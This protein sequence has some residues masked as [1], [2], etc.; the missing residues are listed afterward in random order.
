MEYFTADLLQFFTE[1][2]QKI[3]FASTAGYSPSNPGISAIILESPNFL[4]SYI[5]SLWQLV[6]SVSADNKLVPYNLW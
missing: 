6:H 1:K 5:L 3:A 4:I 2:R